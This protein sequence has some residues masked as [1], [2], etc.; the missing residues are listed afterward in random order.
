MQIMHKIPAIGAAAIASAVMSQQPAQAQNKLAGLVRYPTG[1]KEL[2][3]SDTLRTLYCQHNSQVTELILFADLPQLERINLH[4]CVNLTNLVILAKMGRKPSQREP[5]ITINVS[6]TK[7]QKITFLPE[8]LEEIE[9]QPT[10]LKTLQIQIAEA[11]TQTLQ[12]WQVKDEREETKAVIF[13]RGSLLQSKQ[14]WND[15]WITHSPFIGDKIIQIPTQTRWSRKK[16]FYRLYPI[17]ISQPT[18]QN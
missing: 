5:A 13:W 2:Q 1:T 7:L 4:G 16:V 11:P 18:K 15:E 12:I 3:V 10:T 14:Q 9:V 6:R 8:Q 17:P